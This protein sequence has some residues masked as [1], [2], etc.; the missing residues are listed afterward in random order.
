M[1]EDFKGILRNNIN[2]IPSHVKREANRVADY[3]ANE[4]VHRETKQIIWD[5]RSLKPQTYPNNANSWP[6]K[7]SHP[8]MGCH[9]ERKGTWRRAGRGHLWWLS[10]HTTA[11]YESSH[12]RRP[13][14]IDGASHERAQAGQPEH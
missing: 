9:A 7:I 6:V 2:I 4:G 1:L 11:I 10:P 14:F 8:R 3:L 13:P 5:A 12:L